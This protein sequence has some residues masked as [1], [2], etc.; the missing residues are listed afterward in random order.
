MY[1]TSVSECFVPDMNVTAET[2]GQSPCA[3]TT[4]SAP[5]P[6]SVVI[7]I[8]SGNRPSR[9]AAAS[10][11]PFA[12]V[13]M[14]P[15]SNGSSSSGSSRRRDVGMQVAAPGDAQAVAVQRVCVL[16]AT[17][18]H[19]H[20]GDLCEMAGEEAPDHPGTDHAHPL[21]HPCPFRRSGLVGL[22]HIA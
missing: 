12:F 7:S 15:R 22:E 5:R 14:I 6:L 10:S 18:Q 11:R 16:A 13:A 1:S 3:R 4:S 17:R 9:E 19:R 8:A 2:S 20:L 21:D